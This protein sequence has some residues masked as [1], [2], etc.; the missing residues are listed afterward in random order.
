MPAA[1]DEDPAV[2][3]KRRRWPKRPTCSAPPPSDCGW[4]GRE[5]SARLGDRVAADP[6]DEPVEPTGDEHFAVGQRDLRFL[7]AGNAHRRRLRP[8]DR[9]GGRRSDAGE[10]GEGAGEREKDPGGCHRAR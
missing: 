9:R 1:D 5:L 3:E 8:T 10:G 4:P 6:F 2:G 7:G